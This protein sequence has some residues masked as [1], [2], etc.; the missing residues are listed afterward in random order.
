[1]GSFN[2][3]GAV[4]GSQKTTLIPP[5]VVQGQTLGPV[6]PFV[7]KNI[8]V[9]AY[10]ADRGV[11]KDELGNEAKQWFMSKIPLGTAT[12]QFPDANTPCPAQYSIMPLKLV[13]VPAAVNYIIYK[14]GE[15]YDAGGETLMDVSIAQMMGAVAETGEGE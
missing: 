6:G 5:A 11:S 8:K 3:N 1:M 7:C 13:G 15:T 2:D 12:L 9:D 14:C 4:H 10:D